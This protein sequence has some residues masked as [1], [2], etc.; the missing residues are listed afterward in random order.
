MILTGK[1]R[2]LDNRE[3]ALNAGMAAVEKTRSQKVL[4]EQ[5]IEK[6]FSYHESVPDFVS[7][8][9]GARS[10]RG[11][12]VELQGN[13]GGSNSGSNGGGGGY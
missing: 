3:K 2:L 5:Q 7:N 12:P 10:K 11:Q 1:R 4:L 8:A 9:G 6:G 13:S